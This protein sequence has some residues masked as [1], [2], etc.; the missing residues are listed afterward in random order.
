MTRGQSTREQAARL[1]ERM[2]S[3]ATSKHT[4]DGKEV[5]VTATAGVACF[6]DDAAAPDLLLHRAEDTVRLAKRESRGRIRT[7]DRDANDQ[8]R[9]QMELEGELRT[10]L[11]EQQFVL[12][13]QPKCDR[14]GHIHSL[15]SLVRWAHP[16]RGLVPPMQFI[17]VLERMEIIRD[18]GYWILDEAVRQTAVWHAR[19]H[20]GLSVAVNLSPRQLL[21]P[22]LSERVAAILA[23]R[24]LP[25]ASLELEITESLLVHDVEHTQRVLGA[26]RALGVRNS[27]DDFGTGYSSLIRL[28]ELPVDVIKIDKS[29]V[30]RLGR[31][32]QAE[33]VVRL[34]IQMARHLGK[35]TVAEGVETA[36]QLAFLAEAGCDL[37]QGYYFSRPLEAS[38]FEARLGA[39]VN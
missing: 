16:Q 1:A 19:G 6:P 32:E 37:Y 35:S 29:F 30:D 12:H 17:P 2:I 28:L 20:A 36:E 21:D 38:A 24:R 13:Y 7:W 22:A 4:W 25:G 18:V 9:R 34:V 26:L 14:G 3:V 15:E 31:S 23:N 5:H 27:V 39:E 33:A 11:A 10:A 8:L